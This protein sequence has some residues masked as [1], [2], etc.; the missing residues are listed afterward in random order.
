M[1][2]RCLELTNNLFIDQ[3]AS[4]EDK[5]KWYSP[6]V[7]NN[8][9]SALYQRVVDNQNSH[10]IRLVCCPDQA[11]GFTSNGLRDCAAMTCPSPA[12]SSVLSAA[13]P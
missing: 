7:V 12:A 4:N 8:E 2:W 5:L 13:H 3:K 9:S 10:C 11:K 6:L 1:A